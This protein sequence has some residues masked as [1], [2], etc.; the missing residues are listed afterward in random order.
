MLFCIAKIEFYLESQAI[1]VDNI[2]PFKFRGTAEQDNMG[3][4][5]C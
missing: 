4:F 5:F 1:V 3:A 2:F